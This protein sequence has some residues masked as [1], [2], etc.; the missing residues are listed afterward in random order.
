MRGIMDTRCC[1][2]NRATCCVAEHHC[3]ADDREHRTE[4]ADL[5]DDTT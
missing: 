3:A 4:Q 1:R 2:R 5:Y